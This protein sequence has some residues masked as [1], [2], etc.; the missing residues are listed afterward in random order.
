MGQ[1][2]QPA[3]A[4]PSSAGALSLEQRA[5]YIVGGLMLAA[6]GVR[7]RPN[8]LLSLAAFGIGAYLAW[9][10][11]QG[12]DPVK[13]AITGADPGALKRLTA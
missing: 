13:A 3:R 4:A 9:R 6:A 7:P 5:F 8:K 2:T 1:T 10:G 12:S 11:T